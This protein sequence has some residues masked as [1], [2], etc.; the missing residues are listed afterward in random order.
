MGKIHIISD[1]DILQGC[2]DISGLVIV[3]CHGCYSGV[4][5]IMEP[6][7]ASLKARYKKRLHHM[8]I[9]FDENPDFAKNF[10]L[11]NDPTYLLFHKG[12]LIKRIDEMIPS[13]EFEKILDRI[14]Q[15][16]LT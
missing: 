15:T 6:I 16:N 4:L 5:T 1:D 7:F 13:S 10:R 2:L 11:S 3:E 14:M 8:R 9:N 12:V